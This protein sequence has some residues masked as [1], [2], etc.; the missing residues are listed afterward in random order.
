MKNFL[1]KYKYKIKSLDEI[2]FLRKLNKK[3]FVMCHGN[4]DIVHLG[5]IRHLTY[6]KKFGDILLVTITAD[7]KIIKGAN[8]PH[9]PHDLRALNLAALEIVDFV[10]IDHNSTPILNLKKIKPEFYVKGL[11]Y[12]KSSFSSKTLEEKKTVTQYGGKMYFSPGDLVLSSTNLI[13]KNKPNIDLEKIAFAINAY[14]IDLNELKKK[15]T[16][17]KKIKIHVI[18]DIII[19]KYIN[20]KLIGYNAKTPTPSALYI[21]E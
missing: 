5:H 2:L 3:R 14:S 15:L 13:N 6:A 17:N 8:R 21:N 10:T 19:D 9:V 18:G 4:F 11:E 16:N 20:T 7:S 12:A 1:E